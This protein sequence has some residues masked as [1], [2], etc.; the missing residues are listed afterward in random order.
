VTSGQITS[1]PGQFPSRGVTW[2]HFLSRDGHLLRVTGL[3]EL[4][5]TKTWLIRLLQPL[6][7]DFRSNHITSGHLGSCEVIS[8]HMT[9]TSGELQSCRS[10]NVPKTCIKSLLQPLPVTPS[11]MTSIPGHFRSREVISCNVTANSCVVQPCRGSNVP[12]TWLIGLPQPLPG[13]F[14]SNHA[15]SGSV[16]VTWRFVMSFPVTWLPPPAC[17]SPV[18]AQTYPKLAL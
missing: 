12:K 3:Q 17:Y 11:Q 6:P 2:G 13:Y 7:N 9:A 16:P 18:G 10:S 14:K 5:V 8:C 1:L 4:K 15:T